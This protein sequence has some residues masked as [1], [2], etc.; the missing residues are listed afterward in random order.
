VTFFYPYFV[1]KIGDS[2][3]HNQRHFH[4]I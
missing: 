4:L 3:T 2:Q 1:S